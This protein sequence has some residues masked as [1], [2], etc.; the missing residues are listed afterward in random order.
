MKTS[1]QVLELL[2]ASAGRKEKESLLFEARENTNLQKIFYISLNP[3]V[4][5]FINKFSR[6]KP[7]LLKRSS[8][9]EDERMMEFVEILMKFSRREIVGNAAKEE[10][11]RFLRGSTSIEQKWMERIVH[12]N[13]RVGVKESTLSKIWPSL[14]PTFEVQLAHLL[15][16]ETNSE[17]TKITKILSP[18]KYPVYLDPKLDGFRLVAIKEKGQ[19]SL[20][21]RNGNELET[22]P[23]LKKILEGAAYDDLVLDGEVFGVDWATSASVLLSE[24]NVKDEKLLTFE[25]FDAVH[26]SDWNQKDC[27]KPLR[28][29]QI[30]LREAVTAISS[31]R[32][33][34]VLGALVHSEQELLETYQEHIASGWEGA[35]VKDPEAPYDFKRS[36]AVL[37][38][39]P[40]SSHEGIIVGW[41]EGKSGTKWEGAFG[42]FEVMLS[43]RAITRVGTGFNDLQRRSITLDGPASYKGKIAEV[44]GQLLTDEGRVRFPRFKRFRELS[45]VDASVRALRTELDLFK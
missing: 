9:E 13:L 35:M 29:R 21:T 8:K 41:Y 38:M 14:V 2:E 45:D 10:L 32:V 6:Q 4:V 34:S 22:L 40:C 31:S 37:K 33:Q 28:E 42:G 16:V 1:I 23:S 15:E 17:G 3:Y 7:S 36:N 24:K 5:F 27:R 25:T 44:I 18:I 30:L 20:R 12:K 19:V 43:N 26:I 11:E 39:K